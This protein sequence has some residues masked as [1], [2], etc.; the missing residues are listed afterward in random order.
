MGELLSSEAY[1]EL[2]DTLGPENVSRE[3]ALLEGY[4]FQSF[5]RSEPGTWVA[6]PA[7]VVLPASTEEVQAIVKICNKHKVKYKAHSTGWGAHSG[8]G[9]EGVIQIDLRRMG[10]ILEIDEK[11][12]YA[13]VEAYA[14]CAQLQ[15]E[16]MKRGLNCHI[17][18]AGCGTSPLASATS[19][20]GWGWTGLTTSYSPRNVLGV[21]WVLPSG[22]LLRLGSLGSGYGWFS[23]DGPGPSLRGIMRG[24]MGAFG[25]I[26][27]FTKCA[28]KLF[29]WPGSPQPEVKGRI[30][31]VEVEVPKNTKLYL[32]VFPSFERYA[33]A[34]Y[35]IGDAEIGYMLCKNAIGAVVG[36]AMPRLLRSITKH[37]SL[38]AALKSTQHMFQFMI[39]A[40]SPVQFK[41]HDNTLK[42]IVSECEGMLIDMSSLEDL[43]SMF[44]WSFIRGSMP[45]LIFRTGGSFTTAFGSGECWDNTVLQAKIGAEIKQEFIDKGALIDD[46][47]DNAWGG[48]YE[49]SA[50]YSHQEELAMF[51]PRDQRQAKGKLDYEAATIDASIKESLGVGILAMAPG[52]YEKLGPEAYNYHIWLQKI[53]KALDDK[54]LSE[55]TFFVPPG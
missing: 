28:L 4:A 21:E 14:V 23:G 24:W 5:L 8:P 43:H 16:A 18:G 34:G 7:A 13:V 29:N 42:R 38:K 3:P 9:V 26:G 46:L 48:V 47:A 2:E 51:D 27:I 50:V 19:G 15:A 36:V 37:P 45:P 12:M 44:W 41:Y 33:D 17:I 6:R 11:N 25:G 53:K 10:R 35:K 54:D 52:L 30:F 49:G 40:D 32:C 39:A 55:S 20:W 1:K 22:E 31:D